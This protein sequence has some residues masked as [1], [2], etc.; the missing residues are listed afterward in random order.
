MTL[1]AYPE[2]MPGTPGKQ[3]LV[4]SEGQEVPDSV[5]RNTAARFWTLVRMPDGTEMSVEDWEKNHAPNRESA[6]VRPLVQIVRGMQEDEMKYWLNECFRKN[7]DYS[8]KEGMPQSVKK[9]CTGINQKTF[10]DD[11]VWT[12]IRHEWKEYFGY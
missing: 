5:R 8:I 11:E 4:L 7:N 1:R 6:N 9:L 10:T 12:Q 3:V 2:E